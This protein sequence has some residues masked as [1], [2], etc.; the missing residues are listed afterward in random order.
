MY[1]YKLHLAGFQQLNQGQE[2]DI[3]LGTEIK[4]TKNKMVTLTGCI[5]TETCTGTNVKGN[6]S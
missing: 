2:L 6:L 3:L 4:Q 5:I 1:S